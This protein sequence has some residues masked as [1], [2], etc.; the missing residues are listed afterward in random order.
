ML[1]LFD[2]NDPLGQSPLQMTIKLSCITVCMHGCTSLMTIS[3]SALTGAP[4]KYNR[5]RI[6][7]IQWTTVDFPCQTIDTHT[8]LVQDVRYSPSG[9]HFASGGSDMKLFVYDGKTGDTLGEFI[10]NGHKGSIVRPYLLSYV[11]TI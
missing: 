11:A 6:P 2:N 5:V 9:D 4:Y 3:Y 1:F 8:N 7:L 10:E